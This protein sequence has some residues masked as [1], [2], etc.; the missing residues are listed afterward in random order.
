M[1]L[2]AHVAPDGRLEA[3]IAGPEGKVGAGLVADPGVRVCEI[4][5]HAFK[6]DATLEQLE[7][8]LGTHAARVTA[9]TAELFR[10][11]TAD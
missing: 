3:L 8:I 6:E 10:R 4:P 11:G 7:A 9:A 1:K 2:H 5:D